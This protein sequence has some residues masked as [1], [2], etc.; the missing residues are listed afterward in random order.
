MSQP[1]SSAAAPRRATAASNSPV[2]HSGIEYAQTRFQLDPVDKC[3]GNRSWG[4][5]LAVL[6]AV[7]PDRNRPATC[8]WTVKV[9]DSA[10]GCAKPEDSA[11][12]AELLDGVAEGLDLAAGAAC[13][14]RASRRGG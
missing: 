7:E 9:W 12:G 6:L 1:V 10:A 5:V 13:A 8:D 4:Q 14:R 11:A 2:P 3:V